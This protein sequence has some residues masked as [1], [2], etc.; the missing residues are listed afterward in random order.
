MKRLFKALLFIPGFLT[1]TAAGISGF[2]LLDRIGRADLGVVLGNAVEVGGTPSWRLQG[3]LDKAIELYRAGYFPKILVSGGI[4]WR[5]SNEA[6]VMADY[7]V[8]NGVPREAVLLDEKGQNTYLTAVHTAAL[9]R[10]RG[11]KSVLVISQFYHVPR[12]RLALKKMGLSSIYWAHAH[13]T[14]VRDLYG[15]CREVPAFYFY[16]FRSYPRIQ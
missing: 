15:I 7:L 10:E 3:R 12:S 4:D 5:G 2:G 11:W 13:Y 6:Q 9:M 8:Q 1:L 16:L 14:E